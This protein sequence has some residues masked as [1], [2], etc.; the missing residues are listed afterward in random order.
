MLQK[1]TQWQRMR[2]SQTLWQKQTGR[3]GFRW[4]HEQ[5]LP[6][7]F[8]LDEVQVLVSADVSLE[9]LQLRLS[10]AQEDGRLLDVQDPEL[11]RD[12]FDASALHIKLILRGQLVASGRVILLQGER[13][14][15]EIN[16]TLVELP[17][18]VIVDSEVAEISRICTHPD[19]R[20]GHLLTLLLAECA[21]NAFLRGAQYLIGYCVESLVPVYLRFAGEQLPFSG[22][23]P[24]YN[25]RESLVVRIDL[26]KVVRGEDVPWVA[27]ARFLAPRLGVIEQSAPELHRWSFLLKSQGARLLRPYLNEALKLTLLRSA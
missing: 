14:R 21:W 8:V 22:R 3:L 13:R 15:S 2:I 19:Y 5:G 9:V 26:N 10:A 24:L 17:D 23:H 1:L 18:S 4:F 27:W 12:S 11:L 25:G 16:Q 6:T 7:P 20:R